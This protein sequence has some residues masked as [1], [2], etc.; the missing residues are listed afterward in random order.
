MFGTENLLLFVVSGLL[1]NV[2]P[3]ADT[4]N[5]L[6]YSASQGFRGGGIAALGIAA[7]G[8]VHITST[9]IG[10]SA[11]IATSATA[12]TVLK[13]IGA[14]YLAY[15]GITMFRRNSM[16]TGKI[17][18]IAATKLSTIF[19]Q[20]FLTNALNPKIALFFLAFLPQFVVPDTE[21]KTLAFLFLGILFKFNGTLW[22]LFV[23][24]ASSNLADKLRTSGV[25]TKWIKRTVGF[26]FLYFGAKLAVSQG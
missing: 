3:G 22:N 11:I 1:L 6:K 18:E 2:T 5:I 24:W 16:E 10:V 12:F 8:V 14:A 19:W 21:N 20:S 23:A 13:Y 17:Q 26:L 25:V 15:I 9:I 4:I 7:G